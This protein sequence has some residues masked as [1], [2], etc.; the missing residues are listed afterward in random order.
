MLTIAIANQKGGTAKTTT[1]ANL[2]ACLAHAGR[3]VLMVDFDAQGN[4]TDHFGVVAP[5]EER[6]SSIALLTEKAPDVA[7]IVRPVQPNLSIAPSH[8]GLAEI[9]LLMQGT[10]RREERLT[11]ALDGL[12]YDFCLIDCAPTLGVSTINAFCASYAVLICIQ[13]NKWALQAIRRLMKHVEDVRDEANPGLIYWAL[14]TL[15][16]HNVNLNKEVLDKINETFG[17][18]AMPAIRF[19]TAFPEAAAAAVS[20]VEYAHGS[21]GHQDYVEL[22]REVMRRVGTEAINEAVG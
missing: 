15:H 20:I 21:R 5:D 6:H 17:D 14:P 19:T 3:S 9:D 22:A 11:R 12:K 13:T 7:A 18:L 10:F 2:G 1:T 16:R 4:L 8:I